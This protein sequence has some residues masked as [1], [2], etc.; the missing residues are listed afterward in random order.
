MYNCCYELDIKIPEDYKANALSIWN[1]LYVKE[2]QTVRTTREEHP[3]LFEPLGEMGEYLVTTCRILNNVPEIHG[4]GFMHYANNNHG[5]Y[6]G[7]DEMMKVDAGLNIPLFDLDGIITR[8]YDQDGPWDLGPYDF[9]NDRELIN[10][11]SFTEVDSFEITTKPVLFR[12]GKWHKGDAKG[13]T[14]RRAMM[15]FSCKKNIDWDN[16]VNAW[17]KSGLLIERENV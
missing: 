2:G 3:E 6:P 10:R 1:D 8:W 7:H 9:Y 12:L 16:W 4:T 17:K 13:Y 11:V 5:Y 15:S 14:K